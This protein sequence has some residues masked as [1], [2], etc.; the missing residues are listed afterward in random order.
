M[1]KRIY[2]YI[3]FL[4]LFTI[5]YNIVEG[6][7]SIWFGI[8]DETIALFGFGAD[9]FIEVISGIGILQMVIRIGMNPSGQR[10]PVEI[11]A[12]RITGWGFYLLAAGLIAGAFLNIY[13]HHKPESTLWGIIISIISLAV[14]TGLYKAKTFYGKKINS[15]PVIADARCTLMCVYM[16]LILL[17]SSLIYMLTGFGWIDTVG[18]I[19]LAWF[20]FREG[21]EAFEKAK[22]KACVCAHQ[23]AT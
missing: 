1:E 21:K 6:L 16:S 22:G 8:E 20:S 4:A 11:T 19:G 15:E 12:L 23:C 7:I 13:Q 18:A 9:S 14:M 17:V 2:T 5:G 10:S 3:F